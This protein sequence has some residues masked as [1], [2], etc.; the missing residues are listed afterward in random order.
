MD[1]SFSLEEGSMMNENDAEELKSTFS[2][3]GREHGF[4][5]VEA[6]FYPF[7]EL[8][9]SWQRNR[10]KVAFRIS[11]YLSGC[12]GEILMSYADSLFDRIG[13]CK[14][15]QYNQRVMEWLKSKEFIDRNRPLYLERSRNLLLS[16][17]GEFHH[18]S[19]A[20][21]ELRCKGLVEDA[22]DVY[23]TWTRGDNRKRVGHCSVLMKVI[24]ISSALDS[25]D[26]PDF[27]PEYV[28]YHELLHLES[29]RETLSPRHGPEFRRMER[30][31]PQWQEAEAWLRKVASGQV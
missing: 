22:E 24:A 17:E 31:Y 7:K 14:R 1:S 19:T 27:V 16:D 6:R 25:K 15:V 23:L 13:G 30:L 9:S 5:F 28:L 10:W 12:G 2:S 18:L 4:D 3:R 20:M 29:G 21:D 11:D 26:V 8:K